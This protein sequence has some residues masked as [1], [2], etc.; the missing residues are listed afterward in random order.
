MKGVVIKN[1]GNLYHVRDTEG[2]DLTCWAKGN[3]RLKG[4]RSTSPVVVGDRVFLEV[5]PDGTAFITDIE[6]RDN[7]IVRKASN[8]SKH[9]HILAAN[10]DRALLCIT[11]RFPETT[12]VFI[13]RFLAT[14]EAYSVP[15][16]L[17][18]NKTT[19]TMRRISS[20]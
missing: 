19:C 6:D 20:T 5:N 2:N 14:A 13:D 15:V 17:V 7:Y 16:F 1:T 4:I 18:F 12:T 3:L 11:V 8:L 10:I 9:A